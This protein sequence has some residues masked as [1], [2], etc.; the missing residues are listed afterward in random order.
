MYVF[1]AEMHPVG[2]EGESSLLPDWL[3]LLM[4]ACLRS[5]DYHMTFTAVETLLRLLES[6]QQQQQR[7]WS[8]GSGRLLM[9]TAHFRAILTDT[10]FLEVGFASAAGSCVKEV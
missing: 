9:S 4:G 5:R 7:R 8:E 6:L 2:R 1:Y 10:R 3:L